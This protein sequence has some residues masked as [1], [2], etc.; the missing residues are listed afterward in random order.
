MF[1]SGSESNGRVDLAVW[2]RTVGEDYIKTKSSK[3]KRFLPIQDAKHGELPKSIVKATRATS[4]GQLPLR[5]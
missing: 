4:P 5:E 2:G 3:I 1:V